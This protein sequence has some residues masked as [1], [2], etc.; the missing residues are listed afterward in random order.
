MNL[1]SAT[2]AFLVSFVL[3]AP[4]V[5]FLRPRALSLTAGATL[6]AL[7]ALVVEFL[8]QDALSPLYASAVILVLVAPPVEELLKFFVSGA[9]GANFAAAS[10]AGIGFAATENALYFVAAWGEPTALLVG[11]I[12][13]RAVTDPLLHATASTLTT[14]TWHGRAWGLPAGIALH[15]V[16]NTVALIEMLI[17]PAV[18]LALIAVATVSVAGILVGLRR[19]R[20]VQDTLDDRWRMDLWTG[21]LRAAGAA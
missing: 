15:M 20:L 9:T 12:A 21:A 2:E 17:D 8:A 13:L 3:V 18:G 11:F 16:W 7:S 14:V 19:S 1:A 5:A 6:V 4:F 10:G